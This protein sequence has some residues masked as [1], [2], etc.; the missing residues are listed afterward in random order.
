MKRLRS[1]IIW[2]VV[3][4]LVAWGS[5]SLGENCARKAEPQPI[6]SAVPGTEES[7]DTTQGESSA[8]TTA[9]E[10]EGERDQRIMNM[11]R[12]LSKALKENYLFGIDD[13]QMEIGLYKGLFEATKDPYTVFYTGEEFSRLMED[14]A[15]EFA[16]IGVVVTGGTDGLI[17]VVSPIADTPGARAGI[18]AGDKVLAVDGVNYTAQEMDAAVTHM[19]GE[20]GAPVTLTIQRTEGENVQT[21]D[22]S[23]VREIIHVESVHSQMLEDAVGY[24]QITSFDEPT[25]QA[26]QAHFEDLKAQ[27]AKSVIIDLRNNPG[28]LLTACDEIADYLLGDATIVTTVSKNGEKE[29][30]SSDAEQETLPVVLL[31]NG[32][33]ASASEILTGALRDNQRAIAIGTK[34]YGKGIVQRLFPLFAEPKDGGYKITV[35]EYL[36]PSGAHIHEKGIEP[37]IVVELPEGIQG[38]GVEHREEDTQ[39]QRA[40]EEAKKVQAETPEK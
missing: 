37:D 27:G 21:L 16:G 29:V 32:G 22:I 3:V 23:I 14:T 31:V 12:Y 11:I 19:R 1:N 13:Q 34:T 38:I 5:F 17:T 4:L 39:L 33:S 24:L 6:P 36:T 40:I 9:E 7:G 18:L 28:G 20:V 30:V 25:A 8:S 10:S 35:A 26:F 2:M 15:G